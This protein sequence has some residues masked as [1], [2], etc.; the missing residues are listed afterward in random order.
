MKKCCGSKH[1]GGLK[2]IGY[3]GDERS[4][5]HPKKVQISEREIGREKTKKK[6]GRNISEAKRV[7]KKQKVKKKKKKKRAKQENDDVVVRNV[8]S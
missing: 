8:E 3:G 4:P 1:K 5:N 6:R 7:R 2:M